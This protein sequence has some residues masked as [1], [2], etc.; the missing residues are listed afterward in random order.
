MAATILTISV[1]KYLSLMQNDVNKIKFGEICSAFVCG[2]GHLRKNGSTEKMDLIPKFT[3]LV[4][5]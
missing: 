2:P 1:G 3:E 5:N 4:E